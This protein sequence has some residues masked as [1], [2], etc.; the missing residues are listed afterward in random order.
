MYTVPFIDL[1]G[2]R[3]YDHEGFEHL[4]PDNRST[5]EQYERFKDAILNGVEQRKYI[6]V[7]RMC[8]GEY[9][10]S[11]GRKKGYHQGFIGTIKLILAKLIKTQTTSWGENYSRADNRKLKKRFPELLK[12]ISDHGYIAN[13]FLYNRHHFC[14]EYIEPMRKWYSRHGITFHKDN[15]A[16]FFFVYVMLNGP[17]SLPLFKQRRILI[18]SSFAEDKRASTE[19]ELKRRG[20]SA[21]YFQAVSATSSMLDVLDLTP[22][23]QQADLVLIAAGIGSANI[24]KQC[25]ILQ[26]PCIDSGFCLECIANPAVRAERIYCIPDTEF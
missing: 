22:F 2:F 23:A 9:I 15:Y 8:D 12:F 6:P 21:V 16:S 10:Y 26:V 20:A 24:L 13:H 18:I 14:E 7:M 5:R 3:K 1:P 19:K 4:F 25:E 11:V 17:D